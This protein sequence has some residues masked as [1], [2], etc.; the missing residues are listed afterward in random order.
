MG[1][2][3]ILK[4]FDNNNHSDA[5]YNDLA[6]EG[7]QGTVAWDSLTTTEQNRIKN[8]ILNYRENGS[9]TCN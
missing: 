4:E 8:T 6:W 2:I 1:S 7:L 5:F 3:T 9:K